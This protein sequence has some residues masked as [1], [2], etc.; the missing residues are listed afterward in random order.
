[1]LRVR[2]LA[3]LMVLLTAPFLLAARAQSLGTVTF[4][5]TTQQVY[6]AATG[7]DPGRIAPDATSDTISFYIQAWGN[8]QVVVQSNIPVPFELIASY[9]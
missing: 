7:N 5:P 2:Q 9:T 4:S 8:V 6:D 1:M 3:N